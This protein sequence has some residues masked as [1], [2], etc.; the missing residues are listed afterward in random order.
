MYFGRFIG[1]FRYFEVLFNLCGDI[2]RELD[3]GEV[4]CCQI[5]RVSILVHS[6]DQEFV[7]KMFRC[8]TC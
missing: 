2:I 8:K 7:A 1:T 6:A 4:I 5:G 3:A